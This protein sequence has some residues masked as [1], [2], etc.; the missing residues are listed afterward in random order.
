MTNLRGECNDLAQRIND[1][2]MGNDN[3]VPG[4]SE[5]AAIGIDHRERMGV[6]SQSEGQSEGKSEG[7]IVK[8]D[9][10]QRGERVEGERVLIGQVK[11][12]IELIQ[13]LN[14]K[15][16]RTIEIGNALSSFSPFFSPFFSPP[17]SPSLF[18]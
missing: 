10:R 15:Y 13:R 16:S 4:S 7:E 2:M 14:S 6:G 5:Y 9:N 17:L 8:S 12:R 11:H 18:T 1:K 3:S